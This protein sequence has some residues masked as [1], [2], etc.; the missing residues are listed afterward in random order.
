MTTIERQTN[1]TNTADTFDDLIH[2]AMDEISNKKTTLD[3]SFHVPIEALYTLILLLIVSFAYYQPY[4]TDTHADPTPDPLSAGKRVALL[5]IAEEIDQYQR[6]HNQFPKKIS[7]PLAS[8]LEV[9]YTVL[10][11]NHYQLIMPTPAGVLI[12]DHQ[13]SHED[14]YSDGE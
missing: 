13:D 5:T 11:A 12:L 3:R 6:N 1:K 14:I 7:S 9:E 2:Q 4:S 10:G 8:V